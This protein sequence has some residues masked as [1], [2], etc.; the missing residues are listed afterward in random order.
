MILRKLQDRIVQIH[1]TKFSLAIMSLYIL[2]T[3][4]LIVSIILY[5]FLYRVSRSLKI[6]FNAPTIDKNLIYNDL[7][8]F[9][10]ILTAGVTMQRN[11][12]N[13]KF[14]HMLVEELSLQLSSCLTAV[15]SLILKIGHLNDEIDMFYEKD[16]LEKAFFLR[17]L[18]I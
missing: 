16:T 11:L 18:L 1:L 12:E 5:T 7:E 9:I 6:P 3:Y 2:F 10:Q 17:Y 13:A 4:E 14:E 15:M 8:R